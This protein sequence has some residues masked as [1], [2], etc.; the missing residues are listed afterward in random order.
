MTVREIIPIFWRCTACGHRSVRLY[1]R[2]PIK[3]SMCYV[4]EQLVPEDVGLYNCGLCSKWHGWG[5]CERVIERVV[6]YGDPTK[7]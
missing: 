2:A 4:M 1:D 6:I 5:E 7:D 3:C